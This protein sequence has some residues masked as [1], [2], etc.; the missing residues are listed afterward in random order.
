[1]RRMREGKGPQLSFG[2]LGPNRLVASLEKLNRRLLG[3][4][5]R[6]IVL[7]EAGRAVVL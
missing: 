7:I 6:V 5:S 4:N 1:M 3:G 2:I